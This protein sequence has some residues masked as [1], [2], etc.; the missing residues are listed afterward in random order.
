MNDPSVTAADLNSLRYCISGGAPLPI[1]IRQGF[2]RVADCKL[3]EGYGLSETS[4]VITA[5][6]LEGIVKEGSI[7]QPVPATRISIRSVE[8]PTKEMPL[9]ESGEICAAGPQVMSG[10]WRQEEETKAVFVGEF[11]RTGDVGYMDEDGF[12]Y[13]VDRLK[14]III[15]SG[16]KV[17]PRHVEDAI[18][19]FP[20]VEEVTVVGVP[21]DYRGEAPKAF[22]KMKEGQSASVEEL[23]GF[24]KGRLSPIE[25]P[26]S[27]EFRD[28]LPKTLIGKLSKKELREETSG[29]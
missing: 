12:F 6:P 22:V 10:Y 20:G 1:E 15:C 13:I 3:V 19:E 27:V 17:Y 14:D 7:G 2:E 24:L 29:G 23:L 21:D 18:Y 4:P 8:D 28:E 25:I 9:G 16:Y 26:D 11:F 5:N